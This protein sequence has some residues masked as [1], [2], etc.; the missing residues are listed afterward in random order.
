MFRVPLYIQSSGFE[1]AVPLIFLKMKNLAKF[2]DR[3]LF[4]GTRLELEL[5]QPLEESELIR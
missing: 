4:Q 5:I 1:V 2:G 3:L